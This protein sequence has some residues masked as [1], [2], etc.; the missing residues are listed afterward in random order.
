[1]PSSE[2]ECSSIFAIS[3]AGSEIDACIK[4]YTTCLQMT[5]CCGEVKGGATVSVRSI[6]IVT[7][8][9]PE[10]YGCVNTARCGH[11]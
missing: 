1:M 3:V 11:L 8:V 5:T 6:N 10:A 2:R 4:K 7:T 9:Q